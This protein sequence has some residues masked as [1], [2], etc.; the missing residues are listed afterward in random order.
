VRAAVVVLPPGSEVLDVV[1]VDLPDPRDHE[2][3]VQLAASGVCH[4]QLHNMHAPD[5]SAPITLGHEAAGVVVEVGALVERARIGD[6]VVITWLPTLDP[7]GRRPVPPQLETR[8]HGRVVVR[9]VFTWATHTVVDEMLVVPVP[10]D[11]DLALAAV[12]GCAVMTGAGAVLHS[13]SVPAGASVAVIGAGG[14]G[15][16]AIAAARRVGAD[17]VVA[18][19][20]AA[21]KLELA[22]RFGA[23]HLVDASRLDAVDAVREL[24][25]N[26][27]A[28]DA[29][30]QPVRGADFVF[31][32][33]GAATTTADAIAMAR[34]AW[35]GRRPGGAAVIVG[36]PQTPFTLDAAAL[37]VTEKRIIGSLGGSSVAERDVPLYLEWYRQGTLDLMGL[38][39]TRYRL[40][41]I[42]RATDDLAAGRIPGR[43]IID[44]GL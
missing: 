20:L 12:V 38:V 43:C 14:V 4:S 42:N 26:P 44:F 8:R 2:V 13:A 7:S 3:V 41:D 11:V 33:V 25:P 34:N 39:T 15:L 29:L 9:D 19:D 6:H 5:R 10:P 1:D 35:F 28:F 37:L 22:R 18:V 23:T 30:G 31:D 36:V 24:T 21:E 40:E 17:P 27:G 16:C 32:C